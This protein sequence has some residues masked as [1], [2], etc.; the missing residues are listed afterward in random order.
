[1]AAICLPTLVALLLAC[2]Q[3]AP[4]QP[5]EPGQPPALPEPRTLY[6]SP[7]DPRDVVAWRPLSRDDFLG[8]E[9]PGELARHPGLVGAVSCIGMRMTEAG[10]PRV[11][12]RH[13][14]TGERRYVAQLD[15][16]RFTA[17]FDRMCSWW[18][19]N[20]DDPAYLL[21]HEQLHFD[22]AE[23]AARQLTV[24]MRGDMSLRTSSSSREDATARLDVWIQIEVKRA[25]EL[26]Q[27]RQEQFDR[28]TSAVRSRK[29]QAEWDARL[30]SELEDL[31]AR[32]RASEGS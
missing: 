20:H 10:A 3:G 29:S 5:P 2:A 13:L 12:L 19:E 26:S 17:I 16:P 8:S 22:I 24:D 1:M 21:H 11:T 6:F 28:E 27:Q 9:P 30:R 23:V 32:I 4:A 15:R 7:G 14:P 18:N 31:E 25:L